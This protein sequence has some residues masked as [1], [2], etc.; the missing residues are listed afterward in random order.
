[1]SRVSDLERLEATHPEIAWREPIQITV[2][3]V[4]YRCCRVC[5]AKNGIRGGQAAARAFHDPE[6]FEE[7][8]R[9]EHA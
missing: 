3:G 5:I 9:E 6:S 1:M 8:L 7:H 2:E 4:P